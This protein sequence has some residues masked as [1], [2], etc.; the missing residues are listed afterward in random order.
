M[1][2]K[3]SIISLVAGLCLG[4]LVV[5][6]YFWVFKPYPR[7]PEGPKLTHTQLRQLDD[8]RHRQM[9]KE[10][11][12]FEQIQTLH[13]QL[14]KALLEPT[15]DA[16]TLSILIDQIAEAHA[17]LS[18]NHL[19][20]LLDMRTV[21]TDEQFR[22]MI[23]NRDKMRPPFPKG[24]KKGGLRGEPGRHPGPG[25]GHDFEAPPIP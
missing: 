25:P 24:A 21:L 1:I 16:Q 17:T 15:S 19:N 22:S 3:K 11:L 10:Q 2:D 23:K 7:P 12:V 5:L 8:I 20:G 9:E 4:V 14:D 6:G 13:S 18:K